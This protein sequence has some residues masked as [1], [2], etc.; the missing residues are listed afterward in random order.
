MGLELVSVWLSGQR[1]ADLARVREAGTIVALP[2]ARS[3]GRILADRL[4]ARFVE[5]PL[6][7]GVTATSAFVRLLGEIAAEPARAARF[8]AESVAAVCRHWEWLV[9]RRLLH[10]GLAYYGDPYLMP[11][12]V[13]LASFVGMRVTALAA[14]SRRRELEP[15][16][17]GRAC[18]LPARDGLPAAPAAPPSLEAPSVHSVVWEPRVEAL[19]ALVADVAAQTDLFIANYWGLRWAGQRCPLLK[20]LE[21]GFP[22]RGYHRSRPAPFLGY[23]GA[24]ELVDRMANALGERCE[25][26]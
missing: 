12:L 17:P 21:L 1:V 14:S 3:A 15:W 25:Y 13:E 9:P 7:L 16:G 19:G 6:P 20:Q 5:A 2:H 18:V 4:G 24:L 26:L 10:N 22:S 23:E 11:G 8:D